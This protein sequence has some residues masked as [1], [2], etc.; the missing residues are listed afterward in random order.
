M[1]NLTMHNIETIKVSEIRHLGALGTS[2]RDILFTNEK[3]ERFEITV[4]ANSDS[5]LEIVEVELV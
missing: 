3:G 5:K 4:F 1:N 2:V